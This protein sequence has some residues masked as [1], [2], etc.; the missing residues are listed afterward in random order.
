MEPNE[1]AKS[2]CPCDNCQ[3]KRNIKTIDDLYPA[4]SEY[5]YVRRTGRRLLLEALYKNWRTLSP[6][7]IQDYAYLCELEE[8]S[9]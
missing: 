7:I 8:N 5:P 2:E 1:I 6:K 9:K 3:K 4:D